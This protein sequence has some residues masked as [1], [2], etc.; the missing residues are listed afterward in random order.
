MQYQYRLVWTAHFSVLAEAKTRTYAACTI[1]LCYG[2]HNAEK[3]LLSGSHPV[4]KCRPT[5]IAGTFSY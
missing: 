3:D 5:H 1:Y 4:T 2:G